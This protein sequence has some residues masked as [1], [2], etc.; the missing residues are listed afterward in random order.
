MPRDAE[1]V[2]TLLTCL[3][4]MVF[5]RLLNVELTTS[6]KIK[7]QNVVKLTYTLREKI[8]TCC[9]VGISVMSDQLNYKIFYDFSYSQTTVLNILQMF[10]K[11]HF[12]FFIDKQ[13]QVQLIIIHF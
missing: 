11:F 8:W 5:I 1:R 6:S 13:T 12:M 4:T 7:K 10:I 9:S 3:I 2:D